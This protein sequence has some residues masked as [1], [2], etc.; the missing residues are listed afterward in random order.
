M[1]IIYLSTK[2]KKTRKQR[3]KQKDAWEAYKAKYGLVENKAR[4]QQIVKQ[5]VM[6]AVKPMT[7]RPGALDHLQHK[8]LNSGAAVAT[9]QEKKTYTG[10]AIIGLATMHKSNIVP[11]FNEQAAK[12]VANMRR[13][14]DQ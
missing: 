7:L 11:I 1:A 12:D 5:T 14:N 6:Q 13:G 9:K 8:S 10:T 2:S 4:T 3:E